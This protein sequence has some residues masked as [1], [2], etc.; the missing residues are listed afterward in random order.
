MDFHDLVNSERELEE[1]G[2]KLLEK[3]SEVESRID[4]LEKAVQKLSNDIQISGVLQNREQQTKE[5]KEESLVKITQF[6]KRLIT[7]WSRFKKKWKIR[8]RVK[9]RCSH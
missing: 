5:E 1:K 2:E 3:K 7:S 4:L 9:V 6:Q 8:N